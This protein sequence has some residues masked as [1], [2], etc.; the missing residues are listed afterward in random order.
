MI[1]QLNLAVWAWIESVRGL[2]QRG[3]ILPFLVLAGLQSAL[4]LLFTQFYQPVLSWFLVPL[5]RLLGGG[6]VLHYPQFFAVLPALFSRANLGFDWL[7]GTLVT[8]V[9]FLWI[10]RS[11]AGLPLG[12]PWSEAGRQYLR[13]LVLRLPVVV[14]LIVLYELLP[15]L[16]T[17]GGGELRGN[18]LRVMRYGAFVLAVAAEWVFLFT[19][20]ALLAQR[21]SVAGSFRESY[22]MLGRAPLAGFLIVLVPNLVQLP[23]STLMRR[24]QSIT[25]NLA[26]ET[27]AWLLIGSI[28]VTVAV[29]YTV[30]AA[31][32]RVFGARSAVGEEE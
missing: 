30:V 25:T 31:A 11:A 23:L 1:S 5:L 21:R 2:R 20:L 17:G 8:G 29:N 28:L 10:W 26:P 24:S 16:L 12:R 3:V 7:F 19:P 22:A 27:V 4:V 32:V 15:R 9:G 18:A 14:L 13:L 6:A